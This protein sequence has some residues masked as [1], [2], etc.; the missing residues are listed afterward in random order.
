MLRFCRGKTFT[1]YILRFPF[2][3][4]LKETCLFLAILKRP[5]PH[6]QTETHTHTRARAR[7]QA[8]THTCIS[9]LRERDD[10]SALR[11]V[12]FALRE[13]GVTL[14]LTLTKP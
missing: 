9:L 3:V 10:T 13:R 6:T 8:R 4:P 7:T 12:S 2:H 11:Y 5:S 14:E 1:I